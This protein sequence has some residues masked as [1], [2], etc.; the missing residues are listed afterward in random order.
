VPTVIEVTTETEVYDVKLNTVLKDALANVRDIAIANCANLL[1]GQRF[2]HQGV[3]VEGHKSN[4]ALLFRFPE[5]SPSAPSDK[6]L[7]IEHNLAQNTV[8]FR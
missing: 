4:A 2:D 3:A 1:C 7:T 5:S 6:A 8:Q